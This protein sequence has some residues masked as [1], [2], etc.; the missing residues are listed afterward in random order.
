MPLPA[1][2][3]VRSVVAYL[4]TL[5]YIAIALF[6]HLVEGAMRDPSSLN[7]PSTREIG[8]ANMIGTEVAVKSPPDG[9]TLL[10]TAT[11]LATVVSFYKKVPFDPLR[12]LVMDIGQIVDSV[13]PLPAPRLTIAHGLDPDRLRQQLD[14]VDEL[15]QRWDDFRILTGIEV[16][17]LVDGSLDQDEDLLDRLDVVVASVHS[18]LRMDGE[19]MT[20]RMVSV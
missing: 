10:C 17:I 1:V 7:K 2:V 16:D 20:K 11:V 18:K 4:V 14:V 15:N 3:A 8:A 6:N 12:D 5:A 13:P 9:Y 19:G